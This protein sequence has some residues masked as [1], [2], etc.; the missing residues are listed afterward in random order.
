YRATDA[1]GRE[2][3]LKVL[4]PEGVATLELRARLEREATAA[5]AIVHPNIARLHFR[6]EAD[7]HTLLAFELVTGGSLEA[8]LAREGRIP[9]RDAA[10]PRGRDARGLEGEG[11]AGRGRRGGWRRCTRRGSPTA[12]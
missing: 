11:P 6:G 4:A 9:W 3:A 7:G 5:A 12:T 10:R 8:R 2:V 1:E